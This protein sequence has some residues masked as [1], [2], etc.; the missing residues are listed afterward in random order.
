MNPST[1]PKRIDPA[2][3]EPRFVPH[4]TLAAVAAGADA[5]FLE[6][7]PD[8]MSAKCDA[9]SQLN[10]QHLENLLRMAINVRKAIGR[11]ENVGTMTAQ[12]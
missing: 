6:A 1:L 2:G 4:L 10:I 7:H 5:L 11:P 9:A 8:P 12:L 3:G